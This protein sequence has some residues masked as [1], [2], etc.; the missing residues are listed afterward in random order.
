MSLVGL[1][2]QP[3][4]PPGRRLRLTRRSLLGGATLS[5]AAAAGLRLAGAELGQ[6][7]PWTRS[8]SAGREQ[9]ASPLGSE[10]AQ[11]AHLLRR[12]TFGATA[13]EFERAA[14][15]GFG[16][17]VDQLLETPAARPP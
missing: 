12:A 9:W 8:G 3:L 14:S 4:P 1:R 10:K 17:T 16:R 15:Q 5:G 7:L 6:L 2:D 11:V 13:E